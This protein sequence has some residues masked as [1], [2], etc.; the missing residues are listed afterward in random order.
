MLELIDTERLAQL[1][2]KL[3]AQ[4]IGRFLGRGECWS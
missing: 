4:S 2:D 1:F 3:I